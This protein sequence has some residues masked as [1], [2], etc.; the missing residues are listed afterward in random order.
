MKRTV[1]LS[2]VPGGGS[3]VAVAG[4]CAYL[5]RFS[6]LLGPTRI[7]IPVCAKPSRDWLTSMSEEAAATTVMNPSTNPGFE[8]STIGKV[9]DTNAY[10][11]LICSG[12]E[13][14]STKCS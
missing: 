3:Y 6:R 11:L 13:N 9:K 14:V 2:S 5:N 4:R 7:T 10:E 1:A 8:L 12:P